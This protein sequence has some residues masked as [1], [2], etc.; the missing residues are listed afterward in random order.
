MTRLE[1]FKQKLADGFVL[2]KVEADELI[3]VAEA[4]QAVCNLGRLDV[5]NPGHVVRLEVAIDNLDA[6]LTPLLKET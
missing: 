3:A 5:L 2:R 1:Q 4:S 6:A